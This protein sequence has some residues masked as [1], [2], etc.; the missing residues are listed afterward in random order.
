ML[1]HYPF[2]FVAVVPYKALRGERMVRLL[3]PYDWAY[4][5]L[6]QPLA[7]VLSILCCDHDRLGYQP[8]SV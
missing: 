1:L 5:K 3:Y 8:D 2:D 7:G 4:A 6:N